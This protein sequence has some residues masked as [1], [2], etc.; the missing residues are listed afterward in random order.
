MRPPRLRCVVRSP[1]AAIAHARCRH[2]GPRRSRRSPF[3]PG[4]VPADA[5]IAIEH[6][7]FAATWQ[8][9]RPTPQRPPWPWRSLGRGPPGFRLC[10][11]CVFGAHRTI[12][13]CGRLGD[14]L[15]PGRPALNGEGRCRSQPARRAPGP[16][17]VDRGRRGELDAPRRTP[18]AARARPPRAPAGGTSL[19]NERGAARWRWW[20]ADTGAPR[21]RPRSRVASRR[22]GPRSRVRP[23]Q[24]W[25][26]WC[27]A[28]LAAHVSGMIPA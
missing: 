8:Q 18:G 2:R 19:S 7:R 1:D 24:A 15:P 25:R 21:G 23:D 22:R 9:R 14:R 27:R 16:S 17:T 5:S 20:T 26:R 11:C 12:S 6:L 28:P 3:A 4:G 10:D 13:R